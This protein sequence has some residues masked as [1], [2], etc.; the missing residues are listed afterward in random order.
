MIPYRNRT[1]S[2]PPPDPPSWINLAAVNKAASCSKLNNFQVVG[3]CLGAAR[4]AEGYLN[5]TPP[6]PYKNPFVYNGRL[7]TEPPSNKAAS[8]DIKSELSVVTAREM[9]EPGAGLDYHGRTEH[10]EACQ[11]LFWGARRVP[12]T[13]F[14]ESHLETRPC[15][16]Q[17]FQPVPP[18]LHSSILHMKHEKK[19]T[20]TL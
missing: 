17:P 16:Q 18:G 10:L 20:P 19:I 13:A 8:R 4:A 12:D 1:S 15:L 9:K 5:P 7:K 3:N 2:A 11:G 14:A 6:I